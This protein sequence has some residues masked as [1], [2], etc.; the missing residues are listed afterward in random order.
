MRACEC[1]RPAD[2][3][4]LDEHLEMP[5]D[6]EDA[7]SGKLVTVRGS[8]LALQ[9]RERGFQGVLCMYSADSL[10]SL[11]QLDAYGAFDLVLTKGISPQVR[12]ITSQR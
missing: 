11:R 7:P 6:G 9:M 10:V 1:G 5:C 2:L 12:A 8:S 4:I 3:V